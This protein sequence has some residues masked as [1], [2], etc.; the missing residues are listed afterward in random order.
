MAGLCRVYRD[1]RQDQKPWPVLREYQMNQI[2]NTRRRLECLPRDVHHISHTS[3]TLISGGT[4]PPS[5]VP[6]PAQDRSLPDPAGAVTW[7]HHPFEGEIRLFIRI[8]GDRR[9]RL[10]ELTIVIGAAISLPDT[11]GS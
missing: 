1:A 10:G 4:G 2:E 9:N 6:A 3:P 11:S 5:A 8:S 7:I